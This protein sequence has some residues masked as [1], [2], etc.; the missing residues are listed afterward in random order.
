[1][2]EI[3]HDGSK[4][5]SEPLFIAFPGILKMLFFTYLAKKTNLVQLF[6]RK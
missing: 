2:T 3:F 6:A 5:F 4:I 1:M